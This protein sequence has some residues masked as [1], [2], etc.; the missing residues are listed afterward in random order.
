[1]KG[2]TIAAL[3][4]LVAAPSAAF[5]QPQFPITCTG[6]LKSSNGIYFFDQESPIS[7][8]RPDDETPCVGASILPNARGCWPLKGKSIRQILTIC[9]PG[10]RCELAGSLR[11]LS[12]GLYCWTAIDWI[13]A[14]DR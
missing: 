10:R 3:A 5:A 4:F 13:A 14:A 9:S 1:M 12:H 2:L 7:G 6:V 8:L 11:N